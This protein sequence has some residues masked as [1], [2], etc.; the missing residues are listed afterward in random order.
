MG[1]AGFELYE[2]D[3]QGV[4][5]C[6]SGE[7]LND[8]ECGG[9]AEV[10]GGLAMRGGARWEDEG[11]SIGSFEG[12]VRHELRAGLTPCNGSPYIGHYTLRLCGG[13]DHYA[14]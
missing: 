12:G 8:S 10:G 1:I 14:R 13:T 3:N 11:C 9:Q 4:Q 6:D 7:V 5:V 2:V